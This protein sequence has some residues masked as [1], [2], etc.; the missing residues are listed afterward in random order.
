MV[1]AR[2][3]YRIWWI[4]ALSIE[5][6]TVKAMLDR[7]HDPLPNIKK[8]ATNTSWEV[9]APYRIVI[10]SLPPASLYGVT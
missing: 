5:L 6:I 1:L 3:D 7:I 9:L 4:R 2:Q 8:T 10:D